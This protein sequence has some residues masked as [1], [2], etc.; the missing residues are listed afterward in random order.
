MKLGSKH[1]EETRRK[2]RES[3]LGYVMP[4][5]QKRKIG[6][7]GKGKVFSEES[8]KKISEA[9]KR[10]LQSPEAREQRG[11]IRRGVKLTPEQKIRC[12]NGRK[13]KSISQAHKD[14]VSA[15]LKGKKQ[16]IEHRRNAGAA[17]RGNR[18]PNWRGES[19]NLKA[20]CRGLFEYRLWRSDVFKRDNYT[21]AL[22]GANKCEVHADHIKAFWRVIKEN[23]LKT[24]EDA[25]RCAE[26]WDINNGR[27]LCEPC[28]RKTDN[29]GFKGCGR[30]QQAPKQEIVYGEPV[31]LAAN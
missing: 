8:R 7:A 25:I 20:L 21:C 29:F 2:L 28:H 1:S 26:L 16:T 13:G 31:F 24:V 12:A 18:N 23:N 27:T 5:E 22:C 30:K 3:H 6:E 10:H 4:E 9:L 14:A 15:A 17:K 11:K 19:V